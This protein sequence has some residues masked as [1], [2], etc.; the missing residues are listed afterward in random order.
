MS[1]AFPIVASALFEK[2]LGVFTEHGICK[3]VVLRISDPVGMFSPDK[4]SSS[5][6]KQIFSQITVNSALTIDSFFIVRFSCVGNY[7]IVEITGP[8]LAFP[9][10]SKAVCN[11]K[12]VAA[13]FPALSFTFV[14]CQA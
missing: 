3:R 2:E 12:K 1:P 6:R 13:I 11:F 4:S 8:Q 10:K 9:A 14:W 7:V 5:S